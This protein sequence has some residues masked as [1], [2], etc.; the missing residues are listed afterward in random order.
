MRKHLEHEANYAAA[1][2]IA[3][4]TSRVTKHAEL[5]TKLHKATS[6]AKDSFAQQFKKRSPPGAARMAAI[7]LR[8]P[9]AAAREA[10]PG[11]HH[12]VIER[13]S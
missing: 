5:K 4:A 1:Y 2:G 12:Q 11:A 8:I 3:H 10:N 13:P 9:T 7:S 6:L